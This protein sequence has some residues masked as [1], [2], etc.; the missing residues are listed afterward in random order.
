MYPSKINENSSLISIRGKTLPHNKTILQKNI[1]TRKRTDLPIR[2]GSVQRVWI[3]HRNSTQ[4]GQ[5]WEKDSYT[6]RKWKIEDT[7]SVY[8]KAFAIPACPYSPISYT[9][10]DC[11]RSPKAISPPLTLLPPPPPRLLFASGCQDCRCSRSRKRE[12]PKIIC[13][14]QLLCFFFFSDSRRSEDTPQKDPSKRSCIRIK[15][16]ATGANSAPKHRWPTKEEL[17]KSNS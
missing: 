7:R 13:F 3:S 5:K 10:P 4:V 9:Q 11:T 17:S 8:A 16:L 14:S 1:C 6:I 12:N 15:T 2:F